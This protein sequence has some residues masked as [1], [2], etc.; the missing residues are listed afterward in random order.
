MRAVFTSVWSIQTGI[1]TLL[2]LSIRGFQKL[3]VIF[4][5]KG[6]TL[7][8]GFGDVEEKSGKMIFK[9]TGGVKFDESVL[10]KETDCNNK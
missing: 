4:L 10:L 1:V 7:V 3:S 5:K 9:N 2:T 6:N 8:E